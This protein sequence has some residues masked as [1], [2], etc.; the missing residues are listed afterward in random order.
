[1]KKV[2]WRAALL[3]GVSYSALA[4]TSARAADAPADQRVG[5][6]EEIVVTARKRE[7]SLQ[8]APLSVSAASGANLEK[9]QITRI[10]NLQAIAPS[11]LVSETSGYP[12]ALNL[13]LRGIGNSDPILTGDSPVAMYVDGVYL[14]RTAG[15][16]MSLTDVQRVEVLRGP[17]G[18]L[19]GRN[20]TGGAVSITTRLPAEDFGGEV[21]LGYA[22]N[23]EVTAQASVDTGNIAHTGVTG[24]VT[25]RHHQM[26][27]YFRNTLTSKSKSAGADDADQFVVSLH[28]EPIQ[29]LTVDYKFDYLH[30]SLYVARFQMTYALPSMVT[31]L[32]N[33]PNVGGGPFTLPS[34]D[35][36][37][38][39]ASSLTTHSQNNVYGNSL[40]INYRV[41]D[42]LK[43][44]SITGYRGFYSNDPSDLS[45][46][47]PLM[48]F[49]SVCPPAL[50]IP[51]C[52]IPE[53]VQPVSAYRAPYDH[54][55]QFQISQEFQAGG[56]YKDLNYV[57]GLF[58][59]SERARETQPSIIDLP[60]VGLGFPNI[61]P[62][63]VQALTVNSL[64]AYGVKSSSKAAFSQVS[65]APSQVLGGKLELTGGLR[66][67]EDK[68]ALDQN[69]TNAVRNLNA[70]FNKW[71]YA[72]SV[73]YQWTDD[74][75]TYARYSTGYK[76]GGF[77]ARS[78]VNGTSTSGAYL[79][80]VATSYEV[81][82]KAE[83]VDHRVRINASVF[84]TKYDDFQISSLFVL[85]GRLVT[86]TYNAGKVDYKGG[87]VEFSV[88]PATGWQ[89]DG[90]FGYVDPQY[91]QYLVAVPSTPG[92]STPVLIDI[93]KVA[94]YGNVAKTTAA[95][96]VQYS[97]APASFGDL[98]LRA[99]WTYKSHLYYTT[100][101]FQNVG[102]PTQ[103]TAVAGTKT[104][105]PLPYITN[106][107][108][109]PPL[110]NVGAQIILD[111]LPIGGGAKWKL[112]LYGKNLLGKHDR[113]GGLD[114]TGLGF[115]DSAW[116]RGRV[117]GATAA[118]KF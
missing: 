100:G 35:V 101:D 58:Y 4:S 31:Y 16:L 13:R 73:K 96:S 95:F 117:F 70:S 8:V 46:S 47:G 79:P 75:M 5:V 18:S 6:L 22:S 116:G 66:Y 48:G 76:A 33:S 114:L 10:D 56:S 15:A 118:A 20:T 107:T 67:T 7:E 82:G 62:F 30:D 109:A 84:K 86:Q 89:I 2:M 41:S 57:F 111:N 60:L 71:T 54:Q 94:Q 88:L 50:G 11:L 38:T 24:R 64:L 34:A 105:T 104:F 52:S 110:D 53:T 91:K 80:E 36:Q 63:N 72:A 98:T 69:D 25:Y 87:E 106:A 3:M 81:G 42:A 99:D 55:K 113:L 14:G 77:S 17:Q 74:V 78:V 61:A 39:Y 92:S 85:N 90:N 103:A 40:A 45:G 28:A 27:G 44:K 19:F 97:F 1:L 49:S 68:K 51:G 32:S 21:Q 65:W 26:D 9:A 93:A 115:I 102:G 108:R 112:T 37:T 59:F 23:N 83:F 12:A 29:D 43:F